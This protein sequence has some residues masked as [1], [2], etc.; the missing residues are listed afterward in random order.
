[1]YKT[2]ADNIQI[3]DNLI[4]KFG[5]LTEIKKK[6]EETYSNLKHV[7]VSRAEMEWHAILSE[8]NLKS[9]EC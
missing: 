7:N 3:H 8:N 6:L 5:R 1:M 9:Q 4:G 2:L